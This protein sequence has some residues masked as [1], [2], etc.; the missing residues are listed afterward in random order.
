MR[1]DRP[2]WL[3][4]SSRRYLGRSSSNGVGHEVMTI[5]LSSPN[6]VL[7]ACGLRHPWAD[8]SD[9]TCGSEHQWDRSGGYRMGGVDG[10]PGAL[11]RTWVISRDGLVAVVEH[12]PV[13]TN[14]RQQIERGARRRYDG[15]FCTIRAARNSVHAFHVLDGPHRGGCLLLESQWTTSL[16]PF[17]EMFGRWVEPV[18]DDPASLARRQAALATPARAGLG[19][20]VVT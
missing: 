13:D 8:G 6:G 1:L 16:G 20:D 4:R 17:L 5:G 9:D 3:G 10:G 19:Q 15:A 18:G 14:A 2:R 12:D 7:C 11:T